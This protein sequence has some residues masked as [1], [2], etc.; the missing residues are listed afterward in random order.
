MPLKVGDTLMLDGFV[1]RRE[2][3]KVVVE[4]RE[5]VQAPRGRANSFRV[6]F[7]PIKGGQPDDHNKIRIWFTDD[8]VRLPVLITAEPS[9]GPIRMT[10]SSATGTKG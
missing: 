10:L 6:A 9:F 4:A 8:A 5:A 7:M 3:W 2:Q 1:E